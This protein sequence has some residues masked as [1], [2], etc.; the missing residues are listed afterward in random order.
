MYQLDN[1]EFYVHDMRQPFRIHYF[2]YIFNIFTSIGYFEQL[3]DNQKVFESVHA[4]LKDGGHILIDFMNSEK[5]IHNLMERE[6]KEIDG[7]QFYIRRE[8][9]NGKILKHIKIE[10]ED[11]VYLYREEV[12]ALMPWHFHTFL[13]ACGFTLVEEFGDY[14]L[15][16]FR[17]KTSDRYIL[18]AKKTS[19]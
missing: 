10:K 12:Q 8:V 6:K 4:A 13:N 14:H 15:N 16:P 19:V 11:R 3:N 9:L 5:V 17:A 18:L 2:D 7:I 1:L